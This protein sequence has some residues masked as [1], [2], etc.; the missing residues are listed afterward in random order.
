MLGA[1]RKSFIGNI[2]NSEAPERFAGSLATTA[3]A[4]QNDVG[5]IRVHDVLEHKRF[6]E[7]MKEIRKV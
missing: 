6:L 3:F 4:F 7:V 5:I 1:S 2:Y